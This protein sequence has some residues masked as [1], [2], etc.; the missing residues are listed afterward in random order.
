[1]KKSFFILL[2][3]GWATVVHAQLNLPK[4]TDITK[5]ATSSLTNFIA[6]PAPVSYT[7]LTLPTKA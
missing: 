7:H 3:I 5:A 2:I 6:P 1:M 4:S